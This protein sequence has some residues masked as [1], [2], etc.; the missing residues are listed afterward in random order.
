MC[1]LAGTSFKME[2]SAYTPIYCYRN[3]YSHRE[4]PCI[5]YMRGAALH[6]GSEHVGCTILSPQ[7]LSRKAPPLNTSDSF[8]LLSHHL[9]ADVRN[10]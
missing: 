1:Q 7:G 6:I 4:H 5:V 2:A 3:D 10:R 9:C 8:A